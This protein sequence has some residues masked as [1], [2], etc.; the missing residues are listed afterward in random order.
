L[1]P[2]LAG[3][4]NPGLQ[5]KVNRIFNSYVVNEYKLVISTLQNQLSVAE[6]YG[7]VCDKQIAVFKNEL[8]NADQ[9]LA[10]AEQQLAT[11]EQQVTTMQDQVQQVHKINNVVAN[12]LY[13]T[14][15]FT[16]QTLDHATTSLNKWAHFHTFTLL[17]LHDANAPLP[18]Y[19]IR[20]TSRGRTTA[21]NK[22]KRKHPNA[23]MLFENKKIPSGVNL[24]KRLKLGKIINTQRNYFA[25]KMTE[26]EFCRRIDK[27]IGIP[28]KPVH[29][30]FNENSEIA[31]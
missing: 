13:A 16:M 10:N 31:Y 14:R 18:Y 25:I 19:A 1:V 3:W 2:S 23:T 27:M 30:V 12:D 15:Q 11:A 5:I 4:C 21:I 9:Q 20:C 22:L 6:Q 7:E 24:Y 8:A 29:I 26:P 28:P 17:K